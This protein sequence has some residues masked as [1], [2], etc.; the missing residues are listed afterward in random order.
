[1]IALKI[2]RAARTA[3]RPRERLRPVAVLGCLL[4]PARDDEQ[5]VVDRETEAETRDEVEGEDREVVDLDREPQP[6]EGERDRA[7]ADEWRHEGRHEPS[8]DPEREEQHEGEGDQLGPPE[9]TLDRLGDLP[10]RDDAAAESHRRVVFEGRREASRSSL[11]RLAS[12]SV[13]KDQNDTSIVD[14][15]PCNGRVFGDPSSN[16]RHVGR[17]AADEGEHT[18][19]GFDSRPALDLGVGE[20]ALGGEIGELLGAGAQPR[21]DGASDPERHEEKRGREKRHGARPR[22]DQMRHASREAGVHRAA[23]HSSP[24]P[25]RASSIRRRLQ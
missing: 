6:E 12:P 15:R 20:P 16:A 2:D 21:H 7:G 4:P 24:R 10:R 14:E 17:A 18:G 5:R 8:K 22:R 23:A 1:M 9:I 19:V 25:D 3:H 11:S 13:E